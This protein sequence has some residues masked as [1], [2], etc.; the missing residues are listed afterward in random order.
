ML[1]KIYEQ[2]FVK[3]W[4][5][6]ASFCARNWE[7]RNFERA[8]AERTKTGFFTA[9]TYPR[10]IF[11]DL[12][13]TNTFYRW[14]RCVL[15]MPVS[16]R[17]TSPMWSMRRRKGSSWMR[18]RNYRQTILIRGSDKIILLPLSFN[19]R[20]RGS[21]RVNYIFLNRSFSLWNWRNNTVMCF[22]WYIYILFSLCNILIKPR[23]RYCAT[24]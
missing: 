16:W 9:F 23:F 18:R 13:K 21:S 2:E 5:K 20:Y 15:I 19:N 24:K 22:F 10:R 17:C 6:I 11:S 12:S 4:D 3:H 8:V 14:L 1:V 7:R